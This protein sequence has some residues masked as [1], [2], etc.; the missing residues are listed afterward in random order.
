MAANASYANLKALETALAKLIEPYREFRPP[1]RTCNV[2]QRYYFV[3]QQKLHKK[4]QRSLSILLVYAGRTNTLDEVVA[5]Y[6]K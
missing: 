3:K 4:G 6:G 2:F 1:Q 5:Q